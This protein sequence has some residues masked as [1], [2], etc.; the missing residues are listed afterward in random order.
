MKGSF[1]ALTQTLEMCKHRRRG[2]KTPPIC[3][4]TI[5]TLSP[6]LPPVVCP[7]FLSGIKH[8]VHSFT[9]TLND[10]PECQGKITKM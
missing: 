6:S 10:C 1:F 9:L 4:L 3:S 5:G 8:S 7:A 2:V